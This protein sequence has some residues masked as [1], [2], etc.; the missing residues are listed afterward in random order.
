MLTPKMFCLTGFEKEET[1]Q[2]M[3]Q[4]SR[5]GGTVIVGKVSWLLRKR[6]VSHVYTWILRIMSTFSVSKNVLLYLNS[7]IQHQNC[8]AALYLAV[9]FFNRRS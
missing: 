2:L 4:I 7:L 9:L 8:S 3:D 6:S 5:L 1:E